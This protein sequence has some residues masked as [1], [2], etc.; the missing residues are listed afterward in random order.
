MIFE[1]AERRRNIVATSL[2]SI[3]VVGVSLLVGSLAA[4]L[5]GPSLHG[6]Y[7]LWVTARALGLASY[8]SLTALVLLGIWLRHPWRFRYPLGHAETRLRVHAALAVATLVLVL[9]HLVSLAADTFAGVGWRG[10]LIPGASH[11][12]TIPVALGVI[13]WFALIV[14]GASAGLAGR[15]GTK[16]WLLVHH[17]ASLTFVVVWLHA[18]LAGTDSI[19]LRLFYAVTGLAFV[20]LTVSRSVATQPANDI[21]RFAGTEMASNSST[22]NAPSQ[23]TSGEEWATRITNERQS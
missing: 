19:R 7:F 3:T 17:G 10:A 8:L 20:L 21:R 2:T 22:G 15:R 9:G 13:A 16:H 23:A 4:R 12:R 14:F 6:R 18:T 1:T 5:V 11:Y